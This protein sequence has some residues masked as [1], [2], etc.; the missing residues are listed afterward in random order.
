M[1]SRIAATSFAGLPL[2]AL[3]AGY[4]VSAVGL[5]PALISSGIVCLLV[6]SY[7]LLRRGPG[8][9]LDAPASVEAT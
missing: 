6:S 7:P 9:V 1:Y 3:L 5:T 4:L 2:G 8:K